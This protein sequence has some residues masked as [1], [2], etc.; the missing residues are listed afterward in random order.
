MSSALGRKTISKPKKK[1]KL[2]RNE[3]VIALQLQA[4]PTYTPYFINTMSFIQF[5]IVLIMCAHAYTEG[6]LAT[7]QLSN[8]RETCSLTSEPLCPEAFN[9]TLITGTYHQRRAK[10]CSQTITGMTKISESNMWL[11]PKRQYLLG[12]GAKFP[13]CMRKDTEIT[14]AL[15]QERLEQCGTPAPT[16]VIPNTC[17]AGINGRLRSRLPY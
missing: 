14:I 13:P 8:G 17:D 10:L 7:W 5:V 9:G 6:D 11:G 16:G 1:H 12:L 4:L 2:R 3:T 15:A